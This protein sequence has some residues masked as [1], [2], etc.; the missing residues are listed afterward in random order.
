MM[1][2]PAAVVIFHGMPNSYMKDRSSF[3]AAVDPKAK[4][5]QKSPKLNSPRQDRRSF[6]SR[7]VKI[8]CETEN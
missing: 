1:F 6:G 7:Q 2:E 3:R 5:N 4:R 8:P